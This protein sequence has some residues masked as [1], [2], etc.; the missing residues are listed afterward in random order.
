MSEPASLDHLTSLG[1]TSY[2][3]RAYLALIRRDSS[4]AAEV[5][6]LSRLPRQRVYDVLTSLVDKGLATTRPGTPVKY[7]A[8]DPQVAMQ[9]LLAHHRAE[10]VRLEGAAEQTA[11]ELTPA[12]REGQRFTDPLEYIEVLRDAAAITARFNELQ[13]A[14]EREINIFT[15]P[16]YAVPPAENV[17]GLKLVRERTARSVYEY[18]LFDD[19]GHVEAVR[20]FVQAGEQARFVESLPLKLAI[21][22]EA[23]V[24]FGLEDPHAGTSGL[25]LAVVEHPAL[26]QILKIAFMDVWESGMTFEQAEEHLGRAP[27]AA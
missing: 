22:D 17:E 9:R 24:V 11:A 3:A 25:T 19:S 1:L 8:A 5:S 4:A 7:S 13:A 27:S 20:T 21:M 12:Y 2:E 14:V 15:R 6:R 23:I 10:L 26:A 18:S 16:P